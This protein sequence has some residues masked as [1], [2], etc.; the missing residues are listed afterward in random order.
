MQEHR[1]VGTW[2]LIFSGKNPKNVETYSRDDPAD[3][4][5]DSQ[6]MTHTVQAADQCVRPAD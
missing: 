4:L 6:H 1:A 3:C 2:G 5:W